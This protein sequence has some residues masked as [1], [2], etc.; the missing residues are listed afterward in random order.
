MNAFVFHDSNLDQVKAKFPNLA[1]KLQDSNIPDGKCMLIRNNTG[2]VGIYFTSTTD[3]RYSNLIKTLEKLIT[4]DFRNF[5]LIQNDSFKVG[6]LYG[7][8]QILG[9]KHNVPIEIS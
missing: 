9:R 3:A 5:S 1:E 8:A 6:A 2:E 7:L 4:K